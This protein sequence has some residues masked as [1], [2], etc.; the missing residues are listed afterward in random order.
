M[1]QFLLLPQPLDAKNDCVPISK[2][3]YLCLSPSMESSVSGVEFCLL[4]DNIPD[5]E[6]AVDCKNR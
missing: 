6:F 1:F 2:D 5:L 3:K 4:N